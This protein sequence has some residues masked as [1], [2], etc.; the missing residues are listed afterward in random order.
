LTLV[1]LRYPFS[2]EE[3]YL[4][5]QKKAR[6]DHVGLWGAAEASQRAEALSASWEEQRQ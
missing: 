6:G 5:V 3:D 4:A 2:R 1:Y